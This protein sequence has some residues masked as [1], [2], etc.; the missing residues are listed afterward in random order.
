MLIQFSA[1]NFR[2][3]AERV[4]FSMR[5]ASNS[6]EVEQD[7]SLIPLSP[8]LRLLRC[9]ALYGANASGKSNLVAAMLQARGL[10]V[11]PS[12]SRGESLPSAPFL[13][14]DDWKRRPTTFEFYFVVDQKVYGYRFTYDERVI[15]NEKLT[16]AEPDALGKELTLFSR[17]GGEIS[18]GPELQSS[19]DDFRFLE[20]VAKGT[21]PNQL[22]LNEAHEREVKEL[23]AVFQW[24]AMTLVIIGPDTQYGPLVEDIEREPAFKEFLQRV[25]R[26]ADT[27][28][29]AVDARRRPL[30]QD[31][32]RDVKAILR[33]KRVRSILG[34]LPVHPHR[35][36]R[37]VESPDGKTTELLSL[38]LKHH[39]AGGDESFEMSQ[40]SDGTLRLLDLAPI[41]YW[42]ERPSPVYIVDE[43]DRSLHTLLAQR[44]VER[45]ILESTQQSARTAPQLL[46]TTHDTNLLDCRRLRPDGVWFAEKDV[47]GASR[48]YSLA[49][50]SAEQL[51]AMEGDLERGY[52]QGRFGGIP[53]IGDPVKL[54]WPKAKRDQG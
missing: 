34:R 17:E 28:I 42:S 6:S 18:F 40:E 4:D 19:T 8:S 2:S 30:D 29:V 27:G 50:F 7:T 9:A 13:L 35:R 25:L 54:G 38:H 47:A 33:N 44:L 53:F 52:L 20:Y 24:F 11:S 46:F 26:W 14:G 36:G 12:V 22:F 1:E 49:D 39:G 10:I 21:R 37:V 45:F 32:R 48:F 3:V 23:E 31:I 16:V 5:A 15:V 51:Q 43:L 41:L